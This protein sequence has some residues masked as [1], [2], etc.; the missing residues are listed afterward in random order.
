MMS[1]HCCR[2]CARV[3]LI[4]FDCVRSLMRAQYLL[5][6]Y[7]IGSTLE[8]TGPENIKGREWIYFE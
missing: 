2:Q 7:K 1:R 5:S 6:E 4:A 3:K 8:G